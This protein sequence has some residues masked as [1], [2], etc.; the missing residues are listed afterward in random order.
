MV[1]GAPSPT[2]RANVG[3]RII[4]R[5]VNRLSEPMSLHWHGM[6]QRSTNIMDG[7]TGVTQRP[8]MPGGVCRL[9]SG[10]V[11]AAFGN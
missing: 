2:L 5:A 3:D 10:A 4:V 11:H 7:V 9:G 1:N 6:L 8:V